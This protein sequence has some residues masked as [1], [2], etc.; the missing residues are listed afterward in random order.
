MAIKRNG[1]RRRNRPELVDPGRATNV[2]IVATI[3]A[4]GFAALLLMQMWLDYIGAG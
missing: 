4:A 3:A 1:S 2:L